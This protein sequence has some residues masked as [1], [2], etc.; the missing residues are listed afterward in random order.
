MIS[1]SARLSC[2]LVY[3][4]QLLLAV[5]PFCLLQDQDESQ[6]EGELKVEDTDS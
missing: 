6:R 1:F 4:D 3:A 5:M 2:P